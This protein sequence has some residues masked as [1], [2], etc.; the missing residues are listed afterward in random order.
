MRPDESLKESQLKDLNKFSILARCIS[1]PQIYFRERN[2]IESHLHNF[3]SDFY[4]A[5]YGYQIF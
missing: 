1:S 3:I 4:E 2:A 5:R